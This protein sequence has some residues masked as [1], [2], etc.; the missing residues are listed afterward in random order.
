M[1]NIA[2]KDA[3]E[4][5][6]VETREWLDS[7]DYVLQSGGPAK[8]A[9][10]LR[11]L[12]VHARQNGVKLPFTANTPY[13]NTIPADEEAVMPGNPD[14][15]RRIKSLVRWNAAAMVVRANKLDEGIGGHNFTLAAAATLYEGGVNHFFSGH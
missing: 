13:I 5:D 3:A 12:T 7:L 1:R 14:I 9:R 2:P 11:A 10:L 6:A 4:L 15:E 8:V